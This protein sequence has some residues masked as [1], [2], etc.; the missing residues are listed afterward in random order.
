V[1]FLRKP[2]R[3]AAVVSTVARVLGNQT[4]RRASG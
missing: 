4:N 1:A 2:F 3:V